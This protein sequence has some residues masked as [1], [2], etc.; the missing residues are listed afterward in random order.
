MSGIFADPALVARK[1]ENAQRLVREELDWTKTIEPLDWIVRHATLRRPR[2]VRKPKPP[3]M[4]RDASALERIRWAYR[5]EGVA[6]VARR[7]MQATRRRLARSIGS[8]H[9]SP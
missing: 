2:P 6:E 1:S 5:A 7:T 3:R 4:P 8:S 9:R